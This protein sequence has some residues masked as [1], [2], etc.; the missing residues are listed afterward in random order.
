MNDDQR[1]PLA[2]LRPYWRVTFAAFLGWFLDAFDQVAL[3]LCLPD[4][5][6]S[7]G[8]DL[9]AMGL[10]ITAQSIGR[11]LGNAG[12]GWLADRYGRKLTFMIGVVWFATFSGATAVAGSYVVMVGIQFLFGIG[13]GGEWTASAALL[14]ES[15]PPRARALASSLMM[16]GYEFGFFCAAAAQ[17]VILPRYGWRALFLLGVA[18]A[19]LAIFIRIGVPESPVWLALRKAPRPAEPQP[20]SGMFRLDGAALQAIA[21]MAVVQ[22]QNAALYTFYPTLLRTVQHLTPGQVF[23]LVAAYCAGSLVG[24]PVCGALATRFGERPVLYAYFLVTIAVIIPFVTVH[25]YPLMFMTALAVGAFGNSIWAVIPHFLSQ[26]FPSATRSF[27]MGTSYA[28]AS[29]GQA[30]SGFFIPWFAT[31]RTLAGAIETS[32]FAGTAALAAI[33]AYRPRMLPAEDMEEAEAQ[34]DP[35]GSGV[36]A[37]SLSRRS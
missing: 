11:V 20:A 27:G 16:M 12:W 28:A 3:L 32:V 21:F 37:A 17:A 14:M 13:F 35:Q 31:G 29:L 1:S 2:L 25:S 5:G 36:V 7:L 26:R 30:W 15:V 22:F 19:L 33:L 4:M 23:P 18:P 9:T 6:R 34:T 8:V 10:I 24:K